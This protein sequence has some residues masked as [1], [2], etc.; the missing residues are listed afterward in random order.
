ML[1]RRTFL[2]ALTAAPLTLPAVARATP[3]LTSR[4]NELEKAS[5]GR[6]GVAVLDTHDGRRFA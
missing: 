1:H 6:L 5:G 4:I 3:D 2:S